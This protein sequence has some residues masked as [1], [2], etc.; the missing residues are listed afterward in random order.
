MIVYLKCEYRN[1]VLP[2]AVQLI[3]QH[4]M[5]IPVLFY[6]ETIQ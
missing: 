6:Q 5:D 4:E 1:P 3:F 2:T